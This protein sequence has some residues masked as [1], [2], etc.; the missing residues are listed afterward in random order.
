MDVNG[1]FGDNKS[2]M[3]EL[4]SEVW[5]DQL[6]QEEVE[7]PQF[8]EDVDSRLR[9]HRE[10]LRWLYL[11]VEKEESIVMY[12]EQLQSANSD[13]ESGAMYAS[14][15]DGLNCSE[16]YTEEF[17]EVEP[18]DLCPPFEGLLVDNSCS[19]A[20]LMSSDLDL[21]RD[22][23]DDSSTGDLLDSFDE[24]DDVAA[25][26]TSESTQ[27]TTYSEYRTQTVMMTKGRDFDIY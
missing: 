16:D 5:G 21:G 26:S 20:S 4:R 3:E 12:L 18:E 13:L 15:D 27:I 6:S 9:R 24:L 22:D 19:M 23:Y 2:I 14:T 8:E 17:I 25:Y 1:S 10:R 7:D 11:E